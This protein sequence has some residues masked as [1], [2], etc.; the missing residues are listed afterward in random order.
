MNM[1]LSI[2]FDKKSKRHWV[3]YREGGTREQHSHFY[4]KSNAMYCRKLIDKNCLPISEEY[5]IAVRRLLTD[6]E[7]SMLN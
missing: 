3:L 5:Q 6:K 7:Y 2:I 1:K 4:T